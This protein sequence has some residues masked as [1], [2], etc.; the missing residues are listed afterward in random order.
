MGASPVVR[1]A[2]NFNDIVNDIEKTGISS[3][4]KTI[5]EF[6]QLI[7]NQ[8]NTSSNSDLEKI[9]KEDMLFSSEVLKAANSSLFRTKNA[10]EI[11]EISKA[12]KTIGW[13]LVHKI[14][15]RLSVKGLVKTIKAR[16]FATWLINRSIDIANISE[17]FLNELKKKNDLLDNVNSVYAQ[18]LLHD[19]GALGLLQVIPSYQKDVMG[20]KLKDNNKTWN[21]AE[22]HIYGFNHSAVGEMLLIRLQLPVSFSTAAKYHQS[23][24]PTKY[25]QHESLIL[26]LIRLAEACLI[27]N[28]KFSEHS[29]FSDFTVIADNKKRFRE[30]QDFSLS[31]QTEFEHTLGINEDIYSEI[32]SNYLDDNFQHEVANNF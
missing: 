6:N 19:I 5:N 26:T 24:E 14:G 28:H 13:D 1:Q 16:I 9:I 17:I 11:T 3:T 8:D 21:A 30:Y 29:A 23:P 31:L 2:Y 4:C 22:D 7:Q 27:D 15:M 18:A 25:P 20:V 32:K 12:I 10:V